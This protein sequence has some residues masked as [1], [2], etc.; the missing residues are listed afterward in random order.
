MEDLPEKLRELTHKK[1]FPFIAVIFFAFLTALVFAL[2]AYQSNNPPLDKL[3]SQVGQEQQGSSRS[4]TPFS[5]I[6]R[7]ISAIS[8]RQKTAG[9][10]QGTDKDGTTGGGKQSPQAQLPDEQQAK[11]IY[12][13][14]QKEALPMPKVDV[15]EYVLK[16]TLP[17]V[18]ESVNIYSLKTNYTDEEVETFASRLGFS[19]ID[20]QN[21][22]LEKGSKLTQIYD[23]KKQLYLGFNRKDGTFVFLSEK[24]IP[25][26]TIT[27]NGNDIAQTF[28]TTIGINH[29]CLRPVSG[30][31]KTSQPDSEYVVLH[32]DW[33][34]IGLPILSSLGMLNLPDNRAL[35]QV[36]LGE[37][38]PD[39]PEHGDI[40]F[41]SNDSLQK[42]P[43][44]FNSII[45]KIDQ[46][47]G[48]ILGV[49]SNFQPI[50]GVSA[51]G[52]ER[53]ITPQQALADLNNQQSEF[54]FATPTGE[55]FIDLR[56]VFAN[57]IAQAQSAEI[58]D[59]VLA[60]NVIPHVATP[61]LCPFWLTRSFGEMQ[62]G[63]G[64]KFIHALRAVDDPRCDFGDILGLSTTLVQAGF[65]PT[66]APTNFK[67]QPSV[68][69]SEGNSPKYGTF[70]F[71]GA[72]QPPQDSS[73]PVADQFTNVVKVGSDPGVYM[74]WIDT[75]TTQCTRGCKPR[76]WYSCL[77][78]EAAQTTSVEDQSLRAEILN[79]RR[80]F[81]SKA[82]FGNREQYPIPDGFTGQIIACSKL[83]TG[84]PSIFIYSEK[85]QK[86]SVS[87]D[88]LGHVGYADPAFTSDKTQWNLT[89]SIDGTLIF[90]NG[91]TRK[92]AHWEYRRYPILEELHSYNLPQEGYVVRSTDVYSFIQQNVA[93]QIGL[94][95]YETQQLI[96]E[97]N[98]EMKNVTSD[99]VK[100]Q[101][102]PYDFLHSY[103]KVSI[104]PTPKS[105]YRY[106]F[107]I[108]PAQKDETLNQPHIEKVVRNGLVVVEV[109]ALANPD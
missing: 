23:F 4:Q 13:K 99:F 52:S 55:G 78:D 94:N 86:V 105:F 70:T 27:S 106:L 61:Y 38:D 51:L 62:T 93:Q 25:V 47:T 45:V 74:C 14:I 49:S 84:S 82:D 107:Y 35:T 9:G 83:T 101:L 104:N 26:D 8:G 24:G 67:P 39:T 102:L 44:D 90:E 22:V 91:I 5:P 41:S 59:F 60:Y 43:T 18:P 42:Q 66:P 28:L 72:G 96:A 30:Y 77:T 80:T 10:G 97:F 31:E 16:T 63:Y 40:A 71:K 79:F 15:D 109:G 76:T 46:A 58:T 2:L 98:R 1:Y 92:R 11:I 103:L 100:L 3:R 29:E 56:T 53:I 7:I 48:N 81:W 87:L 85:P 37:I 17:Q 57:N 32:C 20:G 69:Q 19:P 64:G 95:E 88:P 36:Q 21:A 68:F 108:T 33:Q 12:E 50:E 65:T 89:T 73:C 34:T 54:A 6:D 75:N